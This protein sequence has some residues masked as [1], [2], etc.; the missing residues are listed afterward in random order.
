MRLRTIRNILI[1]VVMLIPFWI[2]MG[3]MIHIIAAADVE[4]SGIDLAAAMRDSFWLQFV[5]YLL[6]LV[7]VGHFF[8][9][10]HPKKLFADWYCADR[11]GDNV[12]EAEPSACGARRPSAGSRL[13]RL[14]A[15][16]VTGL[17]LLPLPIALLPEIRWKDARPALTAIPITYAIGFVQF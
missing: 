16:V 3:V 17:I 15:K 13:L 1:A 4:V 12:S 5:T 8:F 10:K 14:L 11:N 9:D 7:T 6:Y 2:L